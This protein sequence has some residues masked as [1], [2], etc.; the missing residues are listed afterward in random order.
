MTIN[1]GALGSLE[2][3][4]YTVATLDFGD[5]NVTGTLRRG[6]ATLNASPNVKGTLLTLDGG[7]PRTA[8]TDGIKTTTVD[9]CSATAPAM[10]NDAAAAV[11]NANGYN[12]RFND[13]GPFSFGP[14]GTLALVGASTYFAGGGT[15]G[16]AVNAD[17]SGIAS[18]GKGGIQIINT[19]NNNNGGGCCC[20][21]G[22]NPSPSRPGC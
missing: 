14:T 13:P 2:L 19:N 6:C 15:L 9:L 20:F 22:Q 17:G 18:L 12:N 5:G 21:C 8:S 10:P 3:A 11:A 1:L 16:R 7:T 4:P